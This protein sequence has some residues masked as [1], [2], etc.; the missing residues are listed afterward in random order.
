MAAAHFI[1]T[2]THGTVTFNA[3]ISF[4][5]TARLTNLT[6]IWT[7]KCRRGKDFSLPVTFFIQKPHNLGHGFN[8]LLYP[9]YT[10]LSINLDHFS[11]GFITCKEFSMHKIGALR[12]TPT[13]P[14]LPI[15]LHSAPKIHH[16]ITTTQ[17]SEP[18]H[19]FAISMMRWRE[20][21]P[22]WELN[23]QSILLNEWMN[24][25]GLEGWANHH[26]LLIAI[27]RKDHDDWFLSPPIYPSLHDNYLIFTPIVA[28]NLNQSSKHQASY[29]HLKSKLWRF[30][31][32]IN[33]EQ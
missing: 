10:S 29:S 24:E 14:I 19:Y 8:T 20:W 7:R 4:G 28:I 21:E 5:W 11:I 32:S 6:P 16:F 12:K 2:F 25:L 33:I 3:D 18:L 9:L 17:W 1:I 26:V 13:W 30:D 15:I 22:W 23:H 27:P 31:Q